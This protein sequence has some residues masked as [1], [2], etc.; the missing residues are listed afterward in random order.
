MNGKSIC[1]LA[2][3]IGL[4]PIALSYGAQP[5]VVLPLLL[6]LEV[7]E[8]AQVHILRAVMGLYLA[9][10]V[11]W[12]LGVRDS[13]YTAAALMSLVVFMLGLAAGRLLSLVVDG[14]P[15]PV[16]TLYLGLEI[17]FGLVGLWLLR[18]P[19]EAAESRHSKSEG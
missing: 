8:L 6:G 5:E 13:R 15:G 1:L 2:A 9:L 3:A 16:L 18:Q 17:G 19:E 14:Y 7:T 11:F 10:V 12:L 4:V